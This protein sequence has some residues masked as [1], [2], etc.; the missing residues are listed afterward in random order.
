MPRLKYTK[1]ILAPIARQ[2]STFSEMARTLRGPGVHTSL[3]SHLH[4]LLDR[5]SI[6]YNHMLG[7]AHLRGKRSNKIITAKTRLVLR[8]EGSRREH[9]HVLKRCLDEIGRPY[10]CETC[11]LEGKWNGLPLT[12]QIDHRNGRIY[13]DRPKNLR[14]QCPNCHTQTPTFGFLGRSHK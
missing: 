1:E 8:P 2:S 14:Y 13:D 12:L 11:G 9:Y 5:Y 6:P 3:V 4:R 10:K 7:Q